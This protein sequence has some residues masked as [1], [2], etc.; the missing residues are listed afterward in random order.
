MLLR[1]K[2]RVI[3]MKRYEY[4]AAEIFGYSYGHCHEKIEIEKPRFTKYMPSDVK[5]LE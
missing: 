2:W 4:I 3:E 5:Q 1:I